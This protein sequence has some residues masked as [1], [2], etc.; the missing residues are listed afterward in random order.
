MVTGFLEQGF[1]ADHE[2]ALMR[3]SWLWEVNLDRCHIEYLPIL[4]VSMA[5]GKGIHSA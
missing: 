1:A 2:E 5:D 4:P 3:G